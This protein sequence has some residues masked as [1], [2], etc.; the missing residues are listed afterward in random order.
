[1]LDSSRGAGAASIMSRGSRR[2][3]ASAAATAAAVLALTALAACS[4]NDAGAGGPI[5]RLD[6]LPAEAVDVVGQPAYAHAAWSISALDLDTGEMLIDINGERMAEPAS[7]TKTYT[8][9]AAWLRWGPDHV[10]TTPVKAQ[11]DVVGGVLQGDLVLVGMGDITLGG[12]TAAD[13][14][15]DFENFDHNDAN[16]IPGATLTKEDPLAGL[17]DLAAQ[18]KAAGIDA[19]AGDVVVDDRLFHGTLEGQPIS[20]IVVNQNLIDVLVTPG[21]AGE[22]AQVELRPEVAPWH[23]VS[24]VRTASADQS[25]AAMGVSNPQITAEGEITIGGTIAADS[26]P[27]LKVVAMSDPATFARS[28]F[29]EALERAGVA[30]SAPSTRANSTDGLAAPDEIAD[31]ESVAAL[32]SL[33]LAQQATY[34]LKVSYNRGA[35]SYVCLFAAE[36]GSDDCDDGLPEMGRTLADAGLDTTG[37]SLVDG[38]G[39][40]G[41]FITANNGLQLQ[42]IML[43]QP[44]AERWVQTLP[45]L[46]V[47]GSLAE[48][49]VDSPAAGKVHAKTGTLVA[50]DQLNERFRLETK[51]LG[52]VMR[53]ESGRNVAFTIILNNGFTS[54]IDGVLQAND[55]IGVVAASI[56][57]AY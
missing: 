29:I 46:G 5:D 37:I 28:A 33:P 31:L 34:V 30:V 18:V 17:H 12:R 47:D 55:D 49:Q 57:Q 32:A 21:K 22:S 48:V 13:G 19:V 40:A 36:I 45:V 3:V 24:T 50:G 6:T 7:F 2:R 35:Q 41:N 25:G 14:L 56:Q 4:P 20:P 9:G 15:V 16:A 27:V 53:T 51:A 1:M 8:M 23:A 39:L 11:G 10:I 42:Q 44:G 43:A 54:D 26:E 38:S 52:G